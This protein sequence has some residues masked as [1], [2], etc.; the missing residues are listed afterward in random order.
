MLLSA[1]DRIKV[2]RD[3]DYYLLPIRQVKHLL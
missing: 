3:L 1:I 2:T